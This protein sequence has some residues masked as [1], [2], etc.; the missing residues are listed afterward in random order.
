MAKNCRF[1]VATHICAVIALAPERAV[2]SDDA[3]GSVNTN[4]VVAR[5]ILAALARAGLV[6]S[7]RGPSGG[8]R[9]ALSPQEIDLAAIARAIDGAEGPVFAPHAPNPVCPVGRGI[10]PLLTEIVRRADGAR[11]AELAKTRLSDIVARL[12]PPSSG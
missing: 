9:L 1:T 6:S 4:P 3:A 8:Y 11:L 5:R 2:T 7:Q 12:A 10:Q